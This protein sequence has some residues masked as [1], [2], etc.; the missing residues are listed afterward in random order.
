MLHNDFVPQL[1]LVPSPY[2]CWKVM[3]EARI[4]ASLVFTGKLDTPPPHFTALTVLEYTP[5][6]KPIVLAGILR[7]RRRY[8]SVSR[9]IKLNAF[10]RSTQVVSILCRNSRLCSIN[11]RSVKTDCLGFWCFSRWLQTH[12]NSKW[13]STLYAEQCY[14]LPTVVQWNYLRFGGF[15]I[16]KLTGS[17]P[18][19]GLSGDCASTR[20]YGS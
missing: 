16:P 19:H 20:G 8:P 14:T 5:V 11:M 17:N 1:C 13:T 4:S 7:R 12:I 15:G 9:C 6:N 3:E 10:F 2:M 18:C